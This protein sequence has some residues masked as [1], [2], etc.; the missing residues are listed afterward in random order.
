MTQPARDT[1]ELRAFRDRNTLIR[2]VRTMLKGTGLD[3]RELANGLVIS[4]PGHP[5]RGRIYI[6]YARGE[7]SHRRTIWDYLGYLDSSTS[8]SPDAE[9]CVDIHTIISIL[10]GRPDILA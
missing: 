8:A 10:N 6:T 7:V 3:I 5:E 4:H 1:D 2:T 9:P